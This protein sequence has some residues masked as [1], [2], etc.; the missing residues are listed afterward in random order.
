MTRFDRVLLGAVA[1][2]IAALVV[3]AVLYVQAGIL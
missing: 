2:L 3:L 1:L